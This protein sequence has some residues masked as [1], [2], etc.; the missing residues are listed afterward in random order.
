[1][2]KILFTLTF[3]LLCGP[4]FNFPDLNIL[5][6][7]VLAVLSP[8]L[9]IIY[10]LLN[11]ECALFIGICLLLSISFTISV[12]I[13]D[14]ESL[15][16]LVDA[17]ILILTFLS[18]YALVVLYK[19]YFLEYFREKLLVHIQYSY[20]IN[21]IFVVSVMLVPG[22]SQF[23]A[24]VLSQNAKMVGLAEESIRAF[25]LVMGG[26]ATASIVFCIVFNINLCLYLSKKNKLSA[27]CM[28]FSL[29]AI[30]FTGRTGLY[31]VFL[32]LI[33][34]MLLFNFCFYHEFRLIKTLL[35]V[36]RVVLIT[37]VG[38]STMLFTLDSL[39][40]DIFELIVLNNF[41]WA[42]EPVINFFATGAFTTESTSRLSE[43]YEQ[44]SVD[45]TTLFSFWGTGFSGR[46]L[47]N[48]LR[49]DIGYVRAL[50]S[51]GFIGMFLIYFKNIYVLFVGLSNVP[52]VKFERDKVV[53]VVSL[54]L[55]SVVIFLVNFKEYHMN[56]RS[57]LPLLFLLFITVSLNSNKEVR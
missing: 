29:L 8:I 54:I 5:F 50:Y 49:T 11:K 17:S 18:S 28:I 52:K 53:F 38:M 48:I 9:L 3:M 57:G 32:S 31:L 22:V 45:F 16:P 55:Y 34:V 44:D 46:E 25:D 40:P 6:T 13:N 47:D 26:G 10:R 21:C 42:F 1:M 7:F 20:L 2:N 56:V 4:R 35:L 19:V 27:I 30:L 39:S 23:S 14:L 51:V 36:L 33:P 37:I 43:M 12:L 41:G 24:S 15:Y